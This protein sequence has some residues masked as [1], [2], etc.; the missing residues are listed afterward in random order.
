MALL[1][2]LLC[3][4]VKDTFGSS[5]P[6]TVLRDPREEQCSDFYQPSLGVIATVGKDWLPWQTTRSVLH[7]G[8]ESSPE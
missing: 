8:P 7:L 4:L 2:Q 6:H 1:F 3:S 5:S